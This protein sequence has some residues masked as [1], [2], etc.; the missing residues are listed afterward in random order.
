MASLDITKHYQKQQEEVKQLQGRIIF[1]SEPT[2]SLPCSINVKLEIERN[3]NI[4]MR[5]SASQVGSQTVNW[6]ALALGIFV[7]LKTNAWMIAFCIRS[8]LTYEH[9]QVHTVIQWVYGGHALCR[10]V[11][12]EH[13]KVPSTRD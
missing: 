9:Q 1:I 8:I 10:T 4:S 6:T 5:T 13:S 11:I 2:S 7:S 3:I 12:S